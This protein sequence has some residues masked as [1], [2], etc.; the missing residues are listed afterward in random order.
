MSDLPALIYLREGYF[1][2]IWE[3]LLQELCRIIQQKFNNIPLIALIKS[4]AMARLVVKM[5]EVEA[6]LILEPRK[7]VE[8]INQ[9]LE[10]REL[11][12]IT[13]RK[14]LVCHNK[15]TKAP[16]AIININ[17]IAKKADRYLTQILIQY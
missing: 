13:F 16:L 10:V 17:L 14:I 4:P 6:G 1:L 8:M 9:L 7:A 5:V 3:L 11:A 15:V 12:G 2:G